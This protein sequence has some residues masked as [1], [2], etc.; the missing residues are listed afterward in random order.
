MAVLGKQNKTPPSLTVISWNAH[1]FQY[2]NNSKVT[3]LHNYINPFPP[4]DASGRFFCV[5][6]VD[7]YRRL[8]RVPLTDAIR[9][10]L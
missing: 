7:A 6:L 3:K 4:I 1:S 8:F 9:R 10:F 5:P 2:N